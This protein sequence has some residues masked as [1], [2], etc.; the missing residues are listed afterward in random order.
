[1]SYDKTLKKVKKAHEV[2]LLLRKLSIPMATHLTSY[3][4]TLLMIEHGKKQLTTLTPRQYA[5]GKVRLITRPVFGE[6]PKPVA[7]YLLLQT[8]VDGSMAT[9]ERRR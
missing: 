9:T 3:Q 5:N 2:Q 6:E 8:D 7:S 1:M 4:L